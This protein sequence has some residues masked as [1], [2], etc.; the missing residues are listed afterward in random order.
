MAA[1]NRIMDFSRF[2]NESINIDKI[3]DKAGIE[4]EKLKLTFS[5][6]ES[7]IV[8]RL[9]NKFVE[10]YDLLKEAQEAHEDVKEILK[11]KINLSLTAEDKFV[12]KIIET[13]K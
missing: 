11:D 9:V 13:A 10:T 6:Q 4:V 3:Y 1:M 2:I 7:A 5:G 12:T 8:T